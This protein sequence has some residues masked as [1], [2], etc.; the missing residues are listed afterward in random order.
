MGVPTEINLAKGQYAN[1]IVDGFHHESFIGNRYSNEFEF[2]GVKGLTLLSTVT[3][4]LQ[5]YGLSDDLQ[6]VVDGKIKV[7]RF[8]ALNE[9]EDEKQDLVMGFSKSFN[10]TIER[11]NRG[12]QKMLK[13]ATKTLSSQMREVVTPYFDR[14]ALHKWANW[15]AAAGDPGP[16]ITTK[17]DAALT[18]A[19]IIEEILKADTAFFN[20]GVPRVDRYLYVP[21]SIYGI[22]RLADEFIQGPEPSFAKKS[23]GEGL[24]GRIG[25]FDVIEIPDTYLT[26]TEDYGDGTWD[27]SNVQFIATYKKSVLR[28]FKIKQTRILTQNPF[29]DGWLIQGHFYTDAFVVGKRSAGVYVYKKSA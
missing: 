12:D 15:T 23:I 24:V 19:T 2:T 16:G 21:A 17:T 1:K 29:L 7:T 28:P 6:D 26:Q 8:G 11:E 3:Q 13:E 22:L 10:M 18:K 25:S 4:P 5:N 27:D 14:V 20:A 9:V